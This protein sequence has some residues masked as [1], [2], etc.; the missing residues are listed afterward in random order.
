LSPLRQTVFLLS[1]AVTAAGVCRAQEATPASDGAAAERVYTREEV[2]N[3]AVIIEMPDPVFQRKLGDKLLDVS[4]TVKLSVVLLSTGRVGEIEVVAGLSKA[5]NF[6]AVKAARR[7]KFMPATRHGL[8]VSQSI[9]A[10]YTFRLVTNEFG[11]ADELKGV[12][13][14]YV[15]AGGDRESRE[16]ITGEVLRLMPELQIVDRPEQA[17]CVLLFYAYGRT[18]LQPL[19]PTKHPFDPTPP[20]TG[21]GYNAPLKVTVGR[22]WVVRPLAADRQRVLWYYEDTKFSPVERKPTINFARNFVSAYRKAN[23]LP[24]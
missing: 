4:G 5:Q 20:N 11:T 23:G 13:K 12:T 19:S 1:L 14:F 8:P 24:K 10:E 9:V 2:T 7:I 6:A 3:P 16:E 15:D 17:E 21:T 22:G 18:D